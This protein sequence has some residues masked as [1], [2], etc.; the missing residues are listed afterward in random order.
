MD[1]MAK[2]SDG[3]I[4]HILQIPKVQVANVWIGSAPFILESTEEPYLFKEQKFRIDIP[5]KKS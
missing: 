5:K 3:Y 4:D 1:K 2:F